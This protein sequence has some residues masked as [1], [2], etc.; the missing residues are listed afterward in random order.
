[1]SI[2][3][4][5]YDVILTPTVASLPLTSNALDFNVFEKLLLKFMIVTGL[6][7]KVINKNT[8]EFLI[9]KLLYHMPFTPIANITGQPAMSVPLYWDQNGLPH[10]AHF[11]AEVGNDKILFMLAKQLESE[12]PWRNKIPS[13]LYLR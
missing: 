9:D 10:G 12:H 11:M 4:Q 1:M 7:K 6:A 8:L 13:R 3:H 5:K 2:L